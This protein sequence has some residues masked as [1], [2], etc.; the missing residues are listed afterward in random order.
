VSSETHLNKKDDSIAPWTSPA[1]SAVIDD[2]GRLSPIALADMPNP[3]TKKRSNNDNITVTSVPTPPSLTDI[4][5]AYSIN[6]APPTPTTNP[7]TPFAND[8]MSLIPYSPSQLTQHGRVISKTFAEPASAAATFVPTTFSIDVFSKAEESIKYLVY[9][10]TWKSFI[11]DMD[12][13]VAAKVEEVVKQ[14]QQNRALSRETSGEGAV[15]EI[16]S[17]VSRA[18]SMQEKSEE[19]EDLEGY[20][21]RDDVHHR[22]L[23]GASGEDVSR[24]EHDKGK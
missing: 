8:D 24:A 6:L 1:A 5:S 21:Y 11:N 19:Y 3:D 13:E 14:K 10:N 12:D 2:N 16:G 15:L 18:G 17:G 20:E 23:D 7:A 4:H 22:Q 9:T